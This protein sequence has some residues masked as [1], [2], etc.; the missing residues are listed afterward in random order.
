MTFY[1]ENET[2]IDFGFDYEKQFQIV[3][4]AILEQEA[5]PYEAEISLLVT[6]ENTIRDINLENRNIDKATDVLSFPMVHFEQPSDFWDLE[7][8]E[9]DCF[10]PET[11]E[12]LLGD[13]VICAEKVLAQAEEYGHSILREFSFLIAHSVLHLCGYDHI[14]EEDA[15]VIER[16]QKTILSALMI[17]R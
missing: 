14:S 10:H 9:E 6:D 1:A 11:G 3:A 5:C 15:K 2:D 7:E 4:E 17:E 12:L 16:K 8:R 13:I